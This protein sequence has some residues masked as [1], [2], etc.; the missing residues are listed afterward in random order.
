MDEVIK[1]RQPPRGLGAVDMPAV[2]GINQRNV[3]GIPSSISQARM[4]SKKYSRC[5]G[6]IHTIHVR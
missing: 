3:K 6:I 5:T 1:Q 4:L 2:A